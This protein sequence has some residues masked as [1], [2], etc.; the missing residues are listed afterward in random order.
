[1]LAE[2]RRRV[3]PAFDEFDETVPD[4]GSDHVY[5]QAIQTQF[6]GIHGHWLVNERRGVISGDGYRI[7]QIRLQSGNGDEVQASI[8]FADSHRRT[9]QELIDEVAIRL[10]YTI[11]LELAFRRNITI[12]IR[13]PSHYTPQ[14]QGAGTHERAVRHRVDTERRRRDYL[15]SLDPTIGLPSIQF[16]DILRVA[17]SPAAGANPAER[18]EGTL[19]FVLGD[20]L[21]TQLSANGYLDVPSVHYADRKRVYRLR[22]DPHHQSDK[23]IRI[24]EETGGRMSYVKDFCIV[25]ADQAVP[26]ADCFLSKWLGLLS[27]ELRTLAVVGRYNIFDP[28]SD[29]YGQHLRETRVPVWQTP[30]D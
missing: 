16:D 29:D 7:V 4:P 22:R 23:R 24:F 19:R 6:P 11:S 2:P 10:G 8:A 27:D 17:G 1:M 15:P 5:V 30:V 18:A 13:P 21:Y 25:R 26:E 12:G 3:Q 14:R 28:Y 20:E 9:P